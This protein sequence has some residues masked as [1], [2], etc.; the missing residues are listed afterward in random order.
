VGVPVGEEG[1]A[2]SERS[3][4]G[5]G[6]GS[7]DSS[8]LEGRGVLSEG[9]LLGLLN[10]GVNSLDSS[11]LVVH[12]EGEDSL[13]GDSNT[14]EDVGLAGIVSVSS[15]TEEDLLIVGV[16]LEGVVETEDGVSGGVGEGTPSGEKS[17][18]NAEFVG[19]TESS[20]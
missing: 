14:R 16:L 3:S 2:E 15:H 11:V 5:D 8:F 10:E 13:F 20:G 6:L 19:V 7:S 12:V 1:E 18:L 9:E 17:V 4:S